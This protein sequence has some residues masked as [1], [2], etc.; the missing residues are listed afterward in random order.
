MADWLLAREYEYWYGEKEKKT[1]AWDT[2]ISAAFPRH[3]FFR[4]DRLNRAQI[5]V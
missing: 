3:I 5:M 1:R 4:A 2:G